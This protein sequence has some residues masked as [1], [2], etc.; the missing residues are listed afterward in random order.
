MQSKRWF[1]YLADD[2]NTYAVLRDESNT[3]LVNGLADVGAIT[4]F[5]PLP[6]GVKPRTVTLQFPSGAIRHCTV[7]KATQ[8]SIIQI[9]DD[10]VSSAIESSDVVGT[11]ARVIYKTGEFLRQQPKVL[12]TGM[13]DTTQP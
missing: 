4:Q 13:I 6:K 3:R 5:K 1:D 9:G 11:H 12:D 2:G 7:L 10:Y 8:Y